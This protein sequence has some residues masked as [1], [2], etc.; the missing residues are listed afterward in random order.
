MTL[1]CRRHPCKYTHR[2]G[3]RLLLRA[4][5]VSHELEDGISVPRRTVSQSGRP[6][7]RLHLLLWCAVADGLRTFQ[8]LTFDAVALMQKQA[9]A[10]LV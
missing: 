7:M 4:D 10:H 2:H 8:S 9:A 6:A 1:R 5:D 3:C